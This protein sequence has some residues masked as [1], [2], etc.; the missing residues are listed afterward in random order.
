MLARYGYCYN[1][2][3]PEL[4]EL[5]LVAAV[6]A[7][8]GIRAFLALAGYPQIGGDGLHIAHMLWGGLFMLLALLLFF[9]V[10]GRPAQRFSAVLGDVGFGTFIDELGKFITSDNNYFYEPTIGL[11]YI[12]F[13]AIFLVLRA[14]RARTELDPDTAQA[15][16]LSLLSGSQGGR[17]SA[18]DAAEARRL[19]D[20]AD[21]T[22]PLVR[23]L[24]SYVSGTEASAA[25]DPGIY[26]K[27]RVAL[28]RQYSR[29]V[30]HRWFSPALLALFA[31]HAFGQIALAILLIVA[32]VINGA[33]LE[34]LL[35]QELQL[36]FTLAARLAS[37]LVEAMLITWGI[38][39]LRYARLTAY[40]W[41][42]RAM[43]VSIFITQVFAFLET[44]FAAL[45]ALA[46]SI[47]IYTAL[48]Y[49]IE[50]ESR[51]TTAF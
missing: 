7:V 10:L 29:L 48:R 17:S 13:I 9:T 2:Y 37:S 31:I 45:G 19:L 35:A 5:F 47:L 34:T 3:A 18:G 20:R 44:Q 15:N 14:A 1:A 46:G 40:R 25:A 30:L 39:K 49:M 33:Y 50:Q 23:A 38:W 6:A 24:K 51:T 8:L 11:I 4:I 32:S 36:S 43:L 12:V 27:M 41:F 26:F 22:S 28:A 16:A 21:P 42:S